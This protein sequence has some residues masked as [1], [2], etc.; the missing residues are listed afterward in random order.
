MSSI[1]FVHGFN[2]KD[3][4]ARTVD[5]LAWFA[6]Q[7]GY[8]V[9]IDQGDYGFFNLW[10]I[11]LIKSY[12]RTRVLY[13]LAKACEEADVIVTHSNGANFV[14]QALNMLG[15]EFNNS[16]LVIHISPALD[17]D[18]DIPQ[19][20]KHQ[21]VLFTPHDKAVKLATFIPF[22]PWGR[23]GA[24]G[25]TGEDNRNT[26][27]EN[28][29]IKSHSAWFKIENVKDTWGHCADFIQEKGK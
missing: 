12:L 15:A 7:E 2:V 13:R 6:R 1:I 25:Y 9:D 26:N 22:H 21:L 17:A 16:K 3:G 27:H 20:V 19:A 24:I 4:G 29:E 14:T 10:M 5:K 18:T 11:R 8:G 28:D 23:M